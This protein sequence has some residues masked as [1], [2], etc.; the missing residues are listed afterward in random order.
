MK[1]HTLH[2]INKLII[3][4]AVVGFTVCCQDDFSS[5]SDYGAI[6]KDVV[7]TIPLELPEMGIK[8]RANINDADRDVV[9]SLMVAVFDA[10]GNITSK[11][12]DNTTVGW[13]EVKDIP[14]NYTDYQEDKYKTVT[15]HT[16]SGPSYIVAVAN[17]ENMGIN[18]DNPT[19]KKTLKELLEECDSWDV[20][21]KIGVARFQKN[22]DTFDYAF[23]YTNAPNITNG[24]PMSGCYSSIPLGGD[25]PSDWS[26]TNFTKINIPATGK[27][28]DGAIHLRRLISHITFNLETAGD[29][30]DLSV[31][32]YTITNVPNYSWLY[33]RGNSE[34]GC[35][36]GDVATTSE[37]AK[38]Y[39][40]TPLNFGGQYV[41]TKEEN[42]KTTHSFDFWMVENKHTGKATDY[43]DREVKTTSG[44]ETLYTSLT[45]DTWTSNNMATHVTIR[46]NVTYTEKP[47]V[48]EDG[49]LTS[50]G[51]E[52][53]RSGIAEY[54]IHLGYIG[55]EA[56][57]F[58]SY[59]NTNYIYN[60][61]VVGLNDIV[62]EANDI[63]QRNSVEGIVTDVDNRSIIL[64]G[65]FGVFN[66]VFTET[67]LTDIENFGYVVTSYESGIA[68]SYTEKDVVP[69]NEKKYINWIEIKSTGDAI[70]LAQYKPAKG[71]SF[72]DSERVIHIDEFYNKLKGLHN[73]DDVN[74]PSTIFTKNSDGNYYFTVFINEYTY[75]PRYS[76]ENYGDESKTTRWHTYINQPTRHFYFR[77]R[78]QVSEDYNSI[79]ARSKYAIA[80]QS[81]QSYY[82]NDGSVSTAIGVEHF[83]EV[84]G[85]NLRRS[86]ENTEISNVNGRWNVYRWLTDNGNTTSPKWSSFVKETTLL[87]IPNASQFTGNRLQGGP[88]L[89]SIESGWNPASGN[90]NITGYG[91]LPALANFDWS[92][93]YFAWDASNKTVTRIKGT[94]KDDYSLY[95]PQ[96]N[97]PTESHYIEAIN[98]CMNR[99]RDE[100]GNGNIDP[101]ELKWYVPASGKY[102]RAILGR[103]SLRDPIMP[104]DKISSLTYVNDGKPNNAR[105]TRWLLYASDE[106]TAWAMEGLSMGD[107][108]F[109]APDGERIPWNVRCIRNLGTNLKDVLK[110]DKVQMAYS[111]VE[112]D[113]KV[114]MAYYD[115]S[116]IRTTKI[117]VSGNTNSGAMKL[118]PVT[119]QL[120]KVYYAF[121]YGDLNKL[122]SGY[123][124][125][126]QNVAN[127]IER[128]D[129]NPCYQVNS[130]WRLPN[131]K[132]LAIMRNL[133]LFDDMDNK[134]GTGS[135]A[136]NRDR[137]AISCTY[138]FFTTGGLGT[139]QGI[140][141]YRDNQNNI[142][143]SLM[144]TRKDGG[145]RLNVE[146]TTYYMYYRCVR[147]VEP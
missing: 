86:F 106:K 80:Q 92:K 123:T 31:E 63:K 35:N 57:D 82:D 16:K 66:V 140:P 125:Q 102:L 118:H 99:N 7:I 81:I 116:S 60:I 88:Q 137:M 1:I 144:V 78:R 90:Q 79:Y 20:F 136:N 42:Q 48:D 98:A 44:T 128:N 67:E 110:T 129:Q 56:S 73:G 40:H 122:N 59:R 26:D 32:S 109:N 2:I 62:V 130:N 104:Y 127:Y 45:G 126:A 25:H 121:E 95:D 3:L 133:G 30:V 6:G 65:H 58:N 138:D 112:K 13:Y 5:K 8:T 107:W 55:S 105:N 22:N 100:N 111:H 84:Q 37:N 46:C 54:T 29:V 12:N 115:N 135:N 94:I 21:L 143:H 68:H 33:E 96:P 113:K 24:I 64:D 119:D 28:S 52:V 69:D 14:D 76:E 34:K 97:S 71:G 9:K 87:L 61:K 36:F 114:I 70:T 50:T 43:N 146:S 131:Q 124:V 72:L 15:L 93:G 89:V 10:S 49:I 39:Y 108:R 77:V 139:G 147:D 103:N 141:S 91:N 19:D 117:N 145:T 38:T 74:S 51:K 4:L 134:S 53:F 83:S 18:S 23:D 120:N 101:E 142:I 41:D 75:E 17:V 27:L 132:E 47:K 85:L 11:K